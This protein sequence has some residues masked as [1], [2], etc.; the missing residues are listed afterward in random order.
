MSGPE[1]MKPDD[2][3]LDEFLAGQGAVRE[4]YR[5]MAQEQAPAH[6]D[7][8][9]LKAAQAAQ[10]AQAAARTMPRV[11]R[12]RWQMPMAATAVV[13]L[14]FGVL[15]EVQ[16]DP[17]V[18][19]EVMAVAVAD[20]AAPV[21]PAPVE[22]VADAAA[23]EALAVEKPVLEEAATEQKQ[24]AAPTA[25]PK[26]APRAEKRA[27][28]PS[29]PPVMA[30]APP[31]AAAPAQPPPVAMAD[32]P[33]V[34]AVA[35][36]ESAAREAAVAGMARESM[37]RRERLAA[38]AAKAEA[39]R[40]PAAAFAAPAAAESLREAMEDAQSSS[41]LPTCPALQAGQRPAIDSAAAAIAVARPLLLQRFGAE[42]MAGYEP[43][44]AEPSGPHW[45][46][47]GSLPEDVVGSPPE[48]ELCAATGSVLRIQPAENAR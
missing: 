44:K 26:P 45:L 20:Q 24:T 34:A 27:A 1:S 42:V 32:A 8:A 37:Q 25:G 9:I 6:L 39:H 35:E 36:A 2:Q 12:S 31:P 17:A 7:A 3:L 19:R 47:K 28:P 43:L 13:V 48:V 29:P 38:P 46:V 14:S 4:R 33:D 10:A 41:R 30:A 21:A 18:Q 40:S 15:L 23:P 16:R 11:R 5:A 22:A